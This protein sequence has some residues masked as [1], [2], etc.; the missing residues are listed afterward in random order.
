[1]LKTQRFVFSPFYENT[2]VIWD[3]ETSDGAIIDPGCYDAKEREVL[4]DYVEKNKINLR[5][6]INTHCHIDHI[7]G[8]DFIKKKYNLVFMAP[9][10]DVFLLD[11]MID[12][13]KNYGVDFTPSPQPD[14]LI[15]EETEIQ[16]GNLLGKF[17][18]TPGHTPGEYCLFFEAA[19]VCFT[20]DVLFNGGIGRTDLWGGNYETL[21]ESIRTKLFVLP[22]DTIVFPGHESSTS[23]GEEIKYNSFLKTS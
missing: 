21:I 17:I 2:Y 16:L 5:Y 14:A 20:G 8:N 18:Y 13:A 22:S 15:S 3:S 12:T 7:F 10:K 1:M 19:K 4:A 23:I 9:E 11:L 6:L